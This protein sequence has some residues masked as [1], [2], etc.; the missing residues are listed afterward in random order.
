MQQQA[1]TLLPRG[2]E[3]GDVYEPATTFLLTPN[4]PVSF[5]LAT[6]HV[7]LHDA[8]GDLVPIDAEEMHLLPPIHTI[9]RYGRRLAT[10]TAPEKIPIH[11]QITLTPIGTVE[12][13][14]KSLKTEHRWSL[15]FQV[16]SASGQDNS[17]SI[18]N[19]Q[20]ADQTFDMNFIKP[21]EI[22]IRETFSS[23][24]N[25][26]R[27]A[28]KPERLME[29]LEEVLAMPRRDWPPSVMR[30]LADAA[31]KLSMQR[32]ISQ[33]HA[34]R[35]WNLIG[36]LLRPGFGY[37]L[38]DFRLRDL[39]KVILSEYKSPLSSEVQL[40][41]YICTRRI[42]GGLG[43][44]QQLQLASDL[45][46]SLFNKKSGRI[47]IKSKAELYPYSERIRAFAALELIDNPLKLRL[48][49]AIIARLK[50]GE[51]ISADYWALGRLGA[52]HLLYGSLV[53]VITRDQCQ[54]WVEQLLAAALPT[55]EQLAFLL[56]QLAR[57]TEHREVNLSRDCIDKI[58]KRFVGS[59]NVE[60]LE[61]LLLQENFLTQS[62]QEQAFG[63]RLPSGLQMM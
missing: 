54:Q 21:A 30:G 60:R 59:A 26:E 1:L 24:P 38:D 40:Q 45:I 48:G 22:V 53:N 17:M 2:S 56:G 7:R 52:R 4:T 10:E 55:D 33:E 16:R 51:G 44:G 58:L 27:S 29:K 62:E 42:A 41:I 9:L 34:A 3:E 28:A 43:K 12:I 32:N 36:F 18:L 37:P 49:N 63:D 47:D 31:L 39:W 8:A 6:S 11:L 25:A 19:K 35:W 46:A 23:S 61:Q 50:A 20:Q 57:K 13:A 15:E 14:L 5:Q